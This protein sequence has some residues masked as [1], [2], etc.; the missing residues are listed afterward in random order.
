MAC[1]ASPRGQRQFHSLVL[2]HSVLTHQVFLAKSFWRRCAVVI[3]SSLCGSIVKAGVSSFPAVILDLGGRGGR[4]VSFVSAYLPH[5]DHPLGDFTST[6]SQPD[7]VAR[8][9]PPGSDLVVG[10][11]ANVMPPQRLQ[12]VSPSSCF[13]TATYSWTS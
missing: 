10:I 9:R 6:V 1:V 8:H 5:G 12:E 4:K 13:V 7:S 2:T 11:D 3:H